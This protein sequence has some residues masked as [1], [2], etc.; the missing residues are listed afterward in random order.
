MSDK[1]I[2]YTSAYN[3]EKMLIRTIESVLAQTH[4]NW[5]WYL[6]DNGSTDN[7][8]DIIRKYASEYP[9]IIPLVNKKNRISEKGNHWHEIIEDY[10]DADWM[11]LLDADDE[12]KPEFLESS[13][14]FAKIHDLD[15]VASGSDFIDAETDEIK[16]VRIS[17]ENIILDSSE[18]FNDF[19]SE[20]HRYMRTVWGKLYRIAVLREFD[21]SKH[22]LKGYGADTSF[23]TQC[24]S[25][26]SRI[27]ILAKSLHIYYISKKS[28]SYKIDDTRLVCDKILDDI[29]ADFLINKCGTISTENEYF[30]NAVYFNGIRDTLN[31]VF[32][33]QVPYAEKINATHKV[34][35][36]NNVRR[37]IEW[38]GFKEEKTQLF[39]SLAKAIATKTEEMQG[40]YPQDDHIETELEI[41]LNRA[42]GVSDEEMF[43]FLIDVKMK[44]PLSS[45]KLDID[46]K[47]SEVMEKSVLLGG[48]T[49]DT[50]VFISDA[51]CAV[52]R[53]DLQAALDEVVRLSDCEIPSEHIECYLM[54]AQY[55]CAEAEYAEGWLYFKKSLAQFL[56]DNARVDEARFEIEEL[57]EMLPS[58]GEVAG[59]REILDSQCDRENL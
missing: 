31:V 51:V 57:E 52:M 41:F 25:L 2:V 43:K 27:G 26:A 46:V 40:R 9:Q 56:L 18:K 16:S 55:V 10:D 20:Y 58:D 39:G 22:V 5:V 28:S 12:Y 38:S 32:A 42:L 59:L 11:C 45:E 44:R 34:L 13:L 36:S 53:D 19:F 47:I 21:L 37:L 49:A 3:A 48:M 50:A 17:P 8:G 33:L 35:L 14:T 29:T 7:T 54:F 1:C 15:I 6:L 4:T 24:F 30:R 23:A